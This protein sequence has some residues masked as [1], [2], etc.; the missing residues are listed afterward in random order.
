MGKHV[1]P[2]PHIVQ[3]AIRDLNDLKNK[4]ETATSD[5]WKSANIPALLDKVHQNYLG[6]ESAWCMPI[7]KTVANSGNA[8]QAL[9]R[10]CKTKQFS[11][12]D[13]QVLKNFL[14]NFITAIQSG[15]GRA[16]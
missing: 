8:I 10:L 6:K 4:L 15:Q 16:A 7:A 2:S 14:P 13:V 3:Q 9:N 12:T 11:Q 1:N 5:T